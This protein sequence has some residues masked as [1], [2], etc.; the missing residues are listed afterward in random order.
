MLRTLIIECDLNATANYAV[1]PLARL[2]RP[3]EE[4]L[5]SAS[6]CFYNSGQPSMATP[7][8]GIADG[9]GCGPRASIDILQA[10]RRRV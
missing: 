2:A 9:V 6:G 4:H 10:A 5:D 1:S 3:G 7:G 8:P